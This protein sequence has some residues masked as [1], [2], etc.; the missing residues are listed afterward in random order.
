MALVINIV[1]IYVKVV[2]S[3]RRDE[4][5]KMYKTISTI[6]DINYFSKCLTNNKI[7]NIHFKMGEKPRTKLF[8]YE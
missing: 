3:V 2:V 5:T 4:K 6:S 1:I 8:D 7:R